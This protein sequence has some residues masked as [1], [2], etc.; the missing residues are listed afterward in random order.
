MKFATEGRNKFY[1]NIQLS[2]SLTL[3]SGCPTV[4]I[5]SYCLGAKVFMKVAF[6]VPASVRIFIF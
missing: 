3:D 2:L 4:Y 6:S 5:N 1:I